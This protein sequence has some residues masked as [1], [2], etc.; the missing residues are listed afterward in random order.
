MYSHQLNRRAA[1]HGTM[2]AAILAL[3]PGARL[4]RAQDG[5]AYDLI[6]L[7]P[8]ESL[9]P[10]DSGFAITGV[11]RIGAINDAG[12]VCGRFAVSDERFSPAIWPE[13]G[14]LRRLKSATLGGEARGI[15]S[16]GTV[17]GR[18]QYE[19]EAGFITRPAV[20]RDGEP[21]NLPGLLFGDEGVA[22]D[23][24]D[25]GVI[26]GGVGTPVIG[27]R[28]VDDEPEELPVPE[29]ATGFAPWR[30]SNDGTIFGVVVLESA[31]DPR[32][33]AFLRGDEFTIFELPEEV[34]GYLDVNGS[35][36]IGMSENE[37]AVVSVGYES[38]IFPIV[39]E[40]DELT[41]V[42]SP[43]DDAN[44]AFW[45]V[46]NDGDAVGYVWRREDGFSTLNG[47]AV[48]RRDGELFDLNALVTP[49]ELTI[50][51]ALAINNAG[52]IAGHALDAN[53]V[54]HGVIL[55]PAS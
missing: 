19:I 20:W 3:Y 17:V 35:T 54:I 2:L 45:D 40:N 55:A 21:T 31:E 27:A 53:G 14:E 16:G 33:V 42:E 22:R 12:D 5:A 28:W 9:V 49:G 29:G 4:A 34:Q 13:T 36:A 15:N 8:F 30:I 37:F 6:D 7:G 41:V 38:T 48:L 26:V 23:I 43:V 32:Q 46:N 25:D 24:N 11:S 52:V 50:N 47:V 10:V 1:L 44:L 51:E 39:I 18:Q